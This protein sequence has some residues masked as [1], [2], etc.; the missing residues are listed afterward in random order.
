MEDETLKK[1]R[2]SMEF[3]L[4]LNIHTSKLF[5]ENSKDFPCLPL[6][7]TITIPLLTSVKVS[8]A[9]SCYFFLDLVILP[10]YNQLCENT[11]II[12][13]SNIY[14]GYSQSPDPLPTKPRIR[15][16]GHS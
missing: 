16:S 12:T 7:I 6:E 9:G 3:F 15:G 4:C 1:Y 11:P 2:I 8:F 5:F 10:L 13:D 14:I